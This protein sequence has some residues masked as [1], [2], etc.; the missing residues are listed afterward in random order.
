MSQLVMQKVNMI[1]VQRQAFLNIVGLVSRDPDIHKRCIDAICADLSQSVFKQ[2]GRPEGDM[3][4]E[5]EVT[6][7]MPDDMSEVKAV[8]YK[9]AGVVYDSRLYMLLKLAIAITTKAPPVKPSANPSS[10]FD[11][12]KAFH[13]L[14][15]DQKNH[16][17]Y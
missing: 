14:Y 16:F 8:D 1:L 7:D 9:C 4:V 15:T 11:S 3:Y 5:Q 13:I 12:G 10:L 17:T 6:I 2:H